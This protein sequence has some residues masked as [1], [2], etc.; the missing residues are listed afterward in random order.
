MARS[1]RVR[2]QRRPH[3]PGTGDELEP[4]GP[5]VGLDITAAKEMQVGGGR[6]AII[7]VLILQVFTENPSPAGTQTGEEVHGK[8]VVFIRQRRVCLSRPEKAGQSTSRSVLEPHADHCPG[9]LGLLSAIV[10]KRIHE[11]LDTASS[12]V[13]VDEAQHSSVGH[14]AETFSCVYKKLMGK[15]VNSKSPEFQLEGKMT[16]I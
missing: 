5:A 10:S 8:H 6:K 4:Q 16:K 2:V 14:T 7:F 15:D 3:S 1:R 9:G 11:K 12:Q 13:H